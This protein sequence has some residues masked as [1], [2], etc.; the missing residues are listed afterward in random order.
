MVRRFAFLPALI[1]VVTGKLFLIGL[2]MFGTGF[3]TGL[4]HVG[5]VEREPVSYKIKMLPL[6]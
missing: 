4:N 6:N 2:K 1:G 3:G 5:P